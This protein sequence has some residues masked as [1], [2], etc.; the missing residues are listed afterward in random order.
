MGH[1][2]P[3]APVIYALNCYDS[4]RW[5]LFMPA[6]PDAELLTLREAAWFLTSTVGEVVQANQLRYA[7][8]K[9]AI[10]LISKEPSRKGGRMRHQVP[11]RGLEQAWR[12][13]MRRREPAK[14][15]HTPPLV[16]AAGLS[17][18]PDD[19]IANDAPPDAPPPA[20]VLSDEDLLASQNP[21]V[22]LPGE[23][24]AEEAT[25][26]YNTSRARKEYHAALKLQLENERTLAGLVRRS[27]MDEATAEVARRVVSGV[28]SVPAAAA[29]R[30]PQLDRAAINVLDEMLRERLAEVAEW[31][32]Q[33]GQK[34]AE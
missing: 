19:A 34:V 20:G 31:I 28:L 6:V 8:E 18:L 17:A 29:V 2:Y 32:P 13:W 15:Q 14:G 26:D 11:R 12:R 22:P 27:E 10:R 33:A 24:G 23:P 7:A 30:L 25:L 1:S 9:G 21:R 5:F 3:Q 4:L 16:T